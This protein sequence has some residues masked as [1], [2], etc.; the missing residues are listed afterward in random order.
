MKESFLHSE[1]PFKDKLVDSGMEADSLDIKALQS[2][3][4]KLVREYKEYFDVDGIHTYDQFLDETLSEFKV[5]KQG[6]DRMKKYGIHVVDA[7]TVIGKNEEGAVKVFTVVDRVFGENLFDI[8]ELTPELKKEIEDLFLNFAKYYSD[9]SDDANT[10]WYHF[11]IGQFVYGNKLDD[12]EKH[13][14]LVDVEPFFDTS[15]DFIDSIVDLFHE[16]MLALNKKFPSIDFSEALQVL[17]RKK[18]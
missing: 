17:D 18:D 16:E 5:A 15:E 6:F 9:L 1:T 8:S 14:Y 7:D 10:F 4:G 11:H 13:L 3:P 2:L 12:N